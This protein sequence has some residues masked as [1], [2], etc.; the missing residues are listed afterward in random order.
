LIQKEKRKIIL[1]EGIPIE[2]TDTNN[3]KTNSI[4]LIG[5]ASKQFMN[6]LSLEENR[7]GYFLPETK[8]DNGYLVHNKVTGENY[9]CIAVYPETYKNSVLSIV[10][11]MFVCNCVININ[12]VQDIWDDYGNK[13]TQLV[14][15]CENELCYIQQV[16]TELR[17]TDPGIH[18]D[19]Q[20]IIYTKFTDINLLDTIEL[21]NEKVSVKVIDNITF[22]F[23]GIAKVQ[24]KL[25]TR[26]IEGGG[27]G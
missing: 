12:S 18:K 27:G 7:R 23:K 1:T 10:T 6:S 25:E 3:N 8:L 2:I 9:L 21:V 16:S 14:K 15:K 13:T 4:G 20:F 17:Q 5:R 26:N 24:V 22:A 11:H 19:A